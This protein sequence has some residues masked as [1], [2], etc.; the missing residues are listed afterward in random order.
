MT[1]MADPARVLEEALALEPA[2]RSRVAVE[3]L[4]SLEA[5]PAIDADRLWAEEIRRRLD[6]IESGT[7]ELEDWETVRAQVH[8]VLKT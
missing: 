5:P 2:D 3:L 1:P 6:E 4:E 7:A 8:A